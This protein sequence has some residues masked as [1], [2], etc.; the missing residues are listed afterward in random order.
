MLWARAWRRNVGGGKAAKMKKEKVRLKGRSR[1]GWD[2]AGRLRENHDS[3]E[4]R[5][6]FIL[7]Y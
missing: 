6:D 5:F 1:A 7:I 3:P 4:P 2:T